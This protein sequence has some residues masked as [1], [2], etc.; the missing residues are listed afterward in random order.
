MRIAKAVKDLRLTA[1]VYNTTYIRWTTHHSG[2]G[3]TYKDIALAEMCDEFGRA[4]GAEDSVATASKVQPQPASTGNT[5]STLQDLAS[6][7]TD[8]GNCDC[9]SPNTTPSNS[10]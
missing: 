6:S 2:P 3:L 7:A 10:P 5:G 1:Q 9:S 8:A 4:F